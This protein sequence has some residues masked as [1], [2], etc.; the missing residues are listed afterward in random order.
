MI[1]ISILGF[2]LILF[3][4]LQVTAIFSQLKKMHNN[5]KEISEIMHQEQ[6]KTNTLLK[7]FL[8]RLE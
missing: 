8:D 2:I 1:I 4:F 3:I 7:T 5:Y 6:V